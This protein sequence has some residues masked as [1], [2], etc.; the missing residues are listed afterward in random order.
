[1]PSEA[2]TLTLPPTTIPITGTLNFWEAQSGIL[3]NDNPQVWRFAAFAG[4]NIALR[5]IGDDANLILMAD[6][7]DIL[8]QGADIS[9]II[10]ITGFYEVMVVG[11]GEYQIGLGYAD[12]DNPNAPTQIPLTQVV[13]I[14]TPNPLLEEL[15]IFMGEILPN[16]PIQQTILDDARQRYTFSGVEDTYIQ[17]EIMADA[18]ENTPRL[19]LFA[20]D[21]TP[22]ATDGGSGANGSA[23]LR[24]IRLPQHGDYAL[25]L[26][27]RSNS[28]YTLVMNTTDRLIPVIATQTILP[29]P[30]PF[31]TYAPPS[32]QPLLAGARLE[33]H[34]P[35]RATLT[36]PDGVYIYPLYAD[37]GTIITIGASPVD[38]PQV[39]L[40]M[41][42]V[43]PEG[44]IVTRATVNG[45][46]SNGDTVIPAY[47]V[48][49]SGVYQVFVTSENGVLGDYLLSYGIGA[50]RSDRYMGNIARDQALTNRIDKRGVRDIWALELQR[51]DTITL[52]VTPN[53]LVFDPILELVRASNPNEL[54]T[55]DDNSGGNRAPFVR[56]LTIP[57]DDL[58]LIR[59]YAKDA[60]SLGSYSLIWRYI[61]RAATPTPPPPATPLM[62]VYDSVALD[63]YVF[64]PIQGYIGQKIEVQVI[65]QSAGFDP[66]V[67][68]IS[69]TGETVIEADDSNGTLNPTFTFTIPADGVYRLRVNGYLSAGDF[70]VHVRELF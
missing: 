58:Y 6:T 42:L 43:D 56:S 39:R 63:T 48:V 67:A 29:T 14:P 66:V 40:R 34:I 64:Y 23:R 49:M 19:T 41:E 35:I 17:I 9:A 46:V 44:T 24:N 70:V 45:S 53:D 50:T 69:P 30:T 15:G 60:A 62:T 21:G 20:P 57:E 18:P 55:I 13:G 22:I 68:L 54:V 26:I 28:T 36:R 12:R 3:T 32:P 61:D 11:S 1:L 31:P 38:N 4:D 52:S 51:G 59:V 2:P 27:G 65:G 16:T 25:Q 10:P 33:N 47:P 5:V 8:T 7:G 37:G